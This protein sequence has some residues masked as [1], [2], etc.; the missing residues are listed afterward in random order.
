MSD[1]GIR[2]SVL[3]PVQA[4]RSGAEI[5]LGSA[6]QRTVLVALLLELNRPVSLAAIIDAVWGQQP[7]GD[8]RGCV[9]S[10]VSRLRRALRPG[11]SSGQ[12]HPVLRSVNGGYQ[13]DGDPS[14][15][16]VVIFEERSAVARDCY[17]R[18]GPAGR[19]R[20][21]PFGTEPVAGRAVR[22]ADRAAGRDRAGP[23]DRASYGRAG[24]ACRDWAE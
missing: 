13:L 5:E 22:R 16:D 10:Y 9:Y 7:P 3:G 20:G 2:Y 15:V 17:R 19:G 12:Q 1:E 23:A 11:G 6:R 21:D 24:N 18:G 14:Q 4:W 8:A